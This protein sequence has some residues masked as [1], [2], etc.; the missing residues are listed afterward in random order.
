MLGEAIH[1]EAAY[2]RTR[3]RQ[4]SDVASGVREETWF[5]HIFLALRQ[6]QE[7]HE[8]RRNFA[9]QPYG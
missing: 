7:D 2:E 5:S 6:R 8:A 1:R 3:F 4:S 9:E